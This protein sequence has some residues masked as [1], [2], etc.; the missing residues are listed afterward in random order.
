MLQGGKHIVYAAKVRQ[1]FKT[2]ASERA[3]AIFVD[4]VLI[5][6]GKKPVNILKQKVS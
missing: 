3:A 4:K 2:F 5:M 6:A 1:S